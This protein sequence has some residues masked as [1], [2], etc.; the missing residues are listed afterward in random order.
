MPMLNRFTASLWNLDTFHVFNDFITDQADTDW[1]DTITDTGTVAIGDEV[2]GVVTLTPSDATVA[3]NDEAVE[4][5]EFMIG[6][7]SEPFR[8][9]KGPVDVR[10]RAGVRITAECAAGLGVKV[11]DAVRIVEMTPPPMLEMPKAV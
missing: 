7:T 8:A 3:D 9:C 6:A 5:P 4:G 1:V 11:G 2:G 10:G